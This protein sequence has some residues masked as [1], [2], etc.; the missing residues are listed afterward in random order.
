VT[1]REHK[2]GEVLRSAREA[3]GVDLTR[4]ERE[5]KI[6]Q[7]YLS[8]LER[9]A[10]PELPGSVYTKGFLRNYGLYLGLDPEYLIDLYRIESSAAI[11]E[12]PTVPTPPRPIATRRARA[13]VVTPGAVLAAMLTVLVVAFVAWLGYE[14]VNFAREPVLRI[15]EPAGSLSAYTETTY[16][17]RGVT[18]PG[19]SVSVSG[20]AENPTVI[21]DEDGRFE[22]EIELQPGSNQFTVVARDEV[23]GRDAGPQTRTINVVTEVAAS[24]TPEPIALELAEPA[25]GAVQNPVPLAGSAPAGAA[26][27]VEASLVEAPP[28]GFT[29][30]DASGTAVAVDPQP[31]APPAPVSLTSG[32]D[33]SFS[34]ELVLPAGTWELTVGAD[35]V[36]PIV[37][38]VSVA[39]AA[40]LTG[41]LSIEDA[42]SYLQVEQDG[43]PLAGV[44]GSISA[45]GEE[46]ALSASESIRIRAGNAVAVRLTINGYDLGVMGAAGAVVDW[47]ISVA[48]G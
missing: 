29:V 5:T 33:G 35:G 41:R 25:E 44:S 39:Q 13:F 37:R 36:E 34:G 2:L 6:R 45:P 31:P 17:V 11:V 23:T 26:I 15:L 19:A 43:A 8:A 9:G 12:R 20:L 30:T 38:R 28:I 18:E 1:E 16:V 47:R 14:F 42:P 22:M 24:Q 46:H 3:K 40:G 27:T 21:A 4:V 7:R 48:G 32:A 10:Y